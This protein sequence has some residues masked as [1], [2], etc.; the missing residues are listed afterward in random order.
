MQEKM[1][2]TVSIFGQAYTLK[3]GADPDYVQDVA[4]FV[5]ERMKEVAEN[6][7]AS[8]TTKVAILAAVNIADELFRE[9]Q[10]RIQALA[11][12]EDRSVQIARLLAKEVGK[13]T[14]SIQ[15]GDSLPGT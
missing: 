5:D 1:S 14:S 13:D 7:S 2:V 6:A 10:K 12:L 3:G 4:A 15:V 8:S 11:T 9:Q